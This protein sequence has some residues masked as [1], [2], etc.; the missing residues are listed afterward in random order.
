MS[1]PGAVTELLR[2]L[3]QCP[4][5]NSRVPGGTG[6]RQGAEILSRWL[7][8]QG[9][10][11][12]LTEVGA[13]TFSVIAAVPGSRPRGRLVLCSHLDT[14][15]VDA[16]DERAFSGHEDG[17]FLWG[18]GSVDAKASVALFSAL[19]ARAVERPPRWDLTLAAVGDEEVTGTGADAFLGGDHQFDA[20][21][22]GEPTELRL[23][24]AHR[25]VLRF[26]ARL[27]GRSAHSSVPEEG[28]NALV[29]GAS[30]VHHLIKRHGERN[31]PV[32][33]LVGSPTLTPTMFHAGHGANVVPSE[34]T[35][36]FDRRT[37]PPE[38]ADEVYEVLVREGQAAH[39]PPGVMVEWGEPRSGPWFE[40]PH[41]APIV[42]AM[43]RALAAAGGDPTP[44][45]APYGSDARRFSAAGIDTVVFGPGNIRVAHARGERLWLEDLWT[46][47]AIL[48]ACLWS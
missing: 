12:T 45:G 41:D 38:S 21:I 13:G 5:I 24:T 48:E 8:R 34:A 33:P 46:A 11:P 23:V 29:G 4:T 7:E 43:Q 44:V 30:L 27:R 32:H 9:V 15:G 3:V 16:D 1:D 25:G 6:E 42:G 47:M 28:A 2:T 36:L 17:G 19:L 10:A 18:R 37:V 39:L 26:E 40:T 20:A 14:V 35:V 31:W 22:V